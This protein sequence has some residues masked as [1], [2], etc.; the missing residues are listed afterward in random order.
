MTSGHERIAP[1]ITSHASLTIMFPFIMP[2]SRF[3]GRQLIFVLAGAVTSV[4]EI[5]REQARG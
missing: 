1:G 4:A 5:K 3:I 2:V